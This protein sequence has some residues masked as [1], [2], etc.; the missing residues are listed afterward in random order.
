MTSRDDLRTRLAGFLE[1]EMGEPYL[2][3]GDDRDLRDG[4]GL[5][6]VDIVGLVMRIERE[7]RI[8]LSLED[9]TP[10][11]TVGEMIDLIASK[12][13]DLAMTTPSPQQ[14]DAQVAA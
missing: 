7:F 2:E 10:I 3:L 4:L 6:S 13:S 14:I 9:L 1:E 8:R 11:K 5:D 12:V